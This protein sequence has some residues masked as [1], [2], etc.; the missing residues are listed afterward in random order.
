LAANQNALVG[1]FFFVEPSAEAAM[2]FE[3]VS[4]PAIDTESE[5]FPA[6]GSFYRTFAS[7]RPNPGH[8]Y[9]SRYLR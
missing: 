2:G 1:D 7:E 5:G 8:A 6:T 4:I 9:Q 3:A